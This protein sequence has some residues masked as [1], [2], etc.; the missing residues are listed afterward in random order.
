VCL[1]ASHVWEGEGAHDEIVTGAWSSCLTPPLLPSSG[2]VPHLVLP[3][4]EPWSS[5]Q[6]FLDEKY[7]IEDGGAIPDLLLRPEG[8]QKV[9]SM[10]EEHCCI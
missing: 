4:G 8:R 6:H 3:G 7:K 9:M 2:H 1:S 5:H 10:E